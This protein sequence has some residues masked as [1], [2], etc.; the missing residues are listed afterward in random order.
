MLS[1]SFSL[2]LSLFFFFL[3][4]KMKFSLG[5]V[6]ALL[7][8]VSVSYGASFSYISTSPVGPTHWGTISPTCN[9]GSQSPINIVSE[10]VCFFFFFFFFFFSLPSSSV[11]FFFFFF[12]AFIFHPFISCNGLKN[13]RFCLFAHPVNG[14]PCFPTTHPS[15]PLPLSPPSDRQHPRPR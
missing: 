12:C 13:A 4:E 5:V 8:C 2:C 9:G 3:R 1:L 6:F 11:L 7:F 14:L 15:P 10:D